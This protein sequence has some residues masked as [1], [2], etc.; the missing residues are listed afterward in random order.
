MKTIAGRIAIIQEQR[1]RLI[2]DNGRG[3]LFTLPHDSRLTYDDLSRVRDK[4]QR[5]VVEYEGEP[6]T[7]SAVAAKIHLLP[8]SN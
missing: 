6:N 8:E 7:I 4:S 3:F 2:A 5:L 1:F